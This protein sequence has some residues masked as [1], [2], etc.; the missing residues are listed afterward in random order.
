MPSR[1]F[2]SMTTTSR[3]AARAFSSG[4][5]RLGTPSAAWAVATFAHDVEQR[6]AEF[7]KLTKLHRGGSERKLAR[8]RLDLRTEIMLDSKVET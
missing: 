6:Q 2:V 4:Q 5:T 8:R 7:S 3:T 1:S